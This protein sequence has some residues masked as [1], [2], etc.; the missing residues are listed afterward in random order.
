LKKKWPVLKTLKG[1]LLLRKEAI[2]MP[3]ILISPVLKEFNNLIRRYKSHRGTYYKS[4]EEKQQKS[5]EQ[6]LALIE[7][8][9][10]L[11]GVDQD[12]N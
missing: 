3:F 6:R 8:L 1:K 12:I 9:K 11:I 4:V 7:E 10:G 2:P 5:L